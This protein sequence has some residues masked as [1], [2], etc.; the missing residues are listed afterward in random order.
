MMTPTSDLSYTFNFVSCTDGD[1]NNYPVVKIGDQLW[2]AENLKTTKYN[3]NSTISNPADNSSWVGSTE[4]GYCWYSND[5]ANKI[6]FGALYNWAAVSS[7]KLCPTGWR[8]PTI[9][10]WQTMTY[11][12][13]G[14]SYSGG[15]LKETGFL[16]WNSPNEGATNQTGF[17]ARAGGYRDATP[18]A[19]YFHQIMTDGYW[20]S[21]TEYSLEKS[22]CTYIHY[23]NAIIWDNNTNP[24]GNGLSVRCIKN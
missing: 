15:N 2:M 13:G 21:S 9:D 11:N 1:N 14:S 5:L 7:G 10:E 16:Y 4:G 6:K 22:R 20:W 24:K 3:D 12:T 17:G 8:M 19:G 18:G 23:Y